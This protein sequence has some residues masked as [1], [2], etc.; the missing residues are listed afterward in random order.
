[1]ESSGGERGGE[2]D[3]QSVCLVIMILNHI[4][5]K[6]TKEVVPFCRKSEPSVC[7]L[8]SSTE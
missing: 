4:S 1:M 5:Y 8:R 3:S 6:G 2:V 7:T